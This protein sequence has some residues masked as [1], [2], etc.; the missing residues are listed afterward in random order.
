VRLLL[1]QHSAGADPE[2][3]RVGT[4]AAVQAALAAQPRRP[5]L[6]VLPEAT[7]VDFGSGD[8]LAERAEP[9]DGP[10]VAMIASLAAGAGVT[11][12]AGMFERHPQG[13][14]PSNT[15]VA[16]GPDGTLLA[17]YR[18]VHLYDAF[19]YRESDRVAAGPPQPVVLDV[20]AAGDAL[21]V[22]L[23][24][25]YDLRFPEQARVLVDAGADLLVLPAAWL[26][27]DQKVE[28]W[29]TLLRAR[30]IEN[31]VYVAAAG[32]AGTRYCGGSS[33]VDPMGVVLAEAPLDADGW[34]AGE[35]TPQRVAQVREVNPSLA[36]RRWR[37]V[38]R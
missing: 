29:R 15:V 30:A 35:A 12:V 3:A 20:P 27:G 11:V 5:D 22:G 9:L 31:T 34:V 13:E 19:G 4:A 32:K 23:L 33:L 28:H 14:P 8:D 16:V 25:C 10:F 17:A 6:V 38:A 24:T 7:Q 36:N 2:Q 1:V 21:R 18:K 37:V 26:A